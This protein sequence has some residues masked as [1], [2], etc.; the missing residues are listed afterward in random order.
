MRL[1]VALDI[2][3]D[4][5]TRIADFR[6]QMRPLAPDV[7]WVGLETFHVTL[8][9]LGETNT[10]AEIQRALRLVKGPPITLTFRD[11][12]FFPTPKSP[13]VFWVGIE[14]DEHLQDVVK[15]IAAALQ[16]LGFERDKGPFKA[17]L[18]LARAGSG[19]PSAIRGERPAPG[20]HQVR[21]RVEALPPPEFG[22]MTAREFYLYESKLSPAGAQYTRLSR[23]PLERPGA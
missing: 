2:D 21:A 14:A 8:Q 7:R 20:F 5:R 22:T 19:R 10:P 3:A 9:F 23:Y 12:G 4:I 1:F 18:T 15:S 17:H 13:R 16:P 6:D 11:A